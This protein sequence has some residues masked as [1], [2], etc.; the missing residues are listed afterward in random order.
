MVGTFVARHIA[1]FT[2][3]ELLELERILELP[4]A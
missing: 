4:G 2:E 1:A 3:A